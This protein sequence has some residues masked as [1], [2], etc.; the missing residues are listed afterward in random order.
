MNFA[1][2]EMLL[3]LWL[4]PLVLLLLVAASRMHE[5]RLGRFAVPASWALFLNPLTS[6]QKWFKRGLLLVALA[7]IVLSLAR[8]RWGFQWRDVKRRG[9]DII[10][11]LDVS[12]SMMAA[13]ISPNRLQRAQ[14]EIIDLLRLLKGDRI[15]LVAFAGSAFLQCP[16]TVDYG[17]AEL[18][19]GEMGPDMFSQQGTSLGDAIRVAL[20][21][22]EQGSPDDT[23]ARAIILITDGEDQGSD[24]LGA[25]EEAAKKGV[26]IFAIG[27]GAPEG[28]PIPEEGG[29]FKK[30]NAGRVVV[31]KLDESLLK[32]IAAKTGGLY[33]RSTTGDADWNAIYS[34]RLAPKASADGT[35]TREREFFERFQWPLA[36]ALLLLLWEARP[37][38]RKEKDITSS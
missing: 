6:R 25:A 27:L 13:D 23:H 1:A 11:A 2:P 30:D 15:G 12:R 38:R 32:D 19:L 9:V 10:V 20:K 21:A 28:A 35:T 5:R 36:L 3:W 14:R 26:P 7:C 37:R 22:L 24:P 33:V 4:L 16:L 31:S 18:F 8:P 29:G 34:E 17:A